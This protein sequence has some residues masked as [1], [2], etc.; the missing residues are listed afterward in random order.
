M[1]VLFWE[2]GSLVAKSR[3]MCNQGRLGMGKGQQKLAGD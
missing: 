1:V 2:G 3:V